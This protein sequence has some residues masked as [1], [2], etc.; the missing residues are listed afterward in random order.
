MDHVN[1]LTS[2]I[3]GIV[4]FLA[5]CTLPLVPGFVAY[6]SHGERE[7]VLKSAILFCLG[8]LTTFLLFGIL[9]GFLGSL[10]GEAKFILEKLGG[11]FVIVLGISMLGIFRLPF[12]HG[13][14]F[15]ERFRQVFKGNHAPFIFGVA[16]AIGWSPCVGPVLAGIF[17][18]A[19]FSFSVLKAIWLFVFFSLGFI[20]PF[21]GVA[22]LI[23]R[24]KKVSFGSSKIFS[25]VA[26]I[27]LIFIGV[28][29]VAGDFNL[30]A[31]WAYS[32]FKD[33]EGINA[34]L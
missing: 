26:G 19:T 14:L 12:F 27:V 34:L 6:L 32:I 5:P 28:L 22:V 1:I 8:F 4:M 10:L 16:I 31:S 18:Y 29:L 25:V 23:K 3:A 20:L 2:F 21:L 7:R 30:L 24:G 15:G 13:Q 33:Y 11:I 17:F 9:A